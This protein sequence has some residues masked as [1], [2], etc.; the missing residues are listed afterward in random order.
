MF[1]ERQ[2]SSGMGR[3]NAGKELT[4]SN[5]HKRLDLW[6]DSVL[7][8]VLRHWPEYGPNLFSSMAKTLTGDQFVKFLSGDAGWW[9]RLKVIFAMPKWPFIKALTKNILPS[10]KSSNAVV[11]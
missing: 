3:V 10:R 7:L 4:F 11:A 6:M 8:T 5:P 2:I 9:I 1:I